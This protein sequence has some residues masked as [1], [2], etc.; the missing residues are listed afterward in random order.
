MALGREDVCLEYKKVLEGK[1]DEDL[2]TGP[3][4]RV[5]PKPSEKKRKGSQ[6]SGSGKKKKK[7]KKGKK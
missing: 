5:G 7:G 2:E 4:W 1:S 3:G 6:D